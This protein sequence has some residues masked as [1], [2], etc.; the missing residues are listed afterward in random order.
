[1]DQSTT[2]TRLL[3]LV[4]LTEHRLSNTLRHEWHFALGCTSP[5]K[6]NR[7]LLVDSKDFTADLERNR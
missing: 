6:I 1:M 5:T 3:A 4:L 2:K 7:Q